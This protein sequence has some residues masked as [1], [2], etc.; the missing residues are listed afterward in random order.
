MKPLFRFS[1]FAGFLLIGIVAYV[2]AAGNARPNVLFICIDDLKPVL[3][4]YGDRL[5]RTPNIDRLAARG[6]VFENAYCNQSLCAPSLNALMSGMRPTS[7]GIYD[8]ATNFRAAV[9]DAVTVAQ[10]FQKHGYRT[11]AVGKI[12]HP[13]HGNRED[14]ASWTVPHFWPDSGSYLTASP[15]K[16]RGPVAPGGADS[17]R[18]VLESAD[19]PDNAYAD[20]ITADEAIRRMRHAKAK[21]DEPQ[22]LAVGFLKPHLPFRVPKKYWDLHDRAKFEPEKITTAPAGAPAYAL[23]DSGELR[24]VAGIPAGPSPAGQQRELIHGYYAAVSYVDAMVGRLLDELDRL[25]LDRNTIVVLWGDHGWHL[26]DHAQWGKKTNYEQATRIPIIVSAPGAARGEKSRALV[27]TVDLYPTLAE[28][29]G[30]PAP[31][32][33]QKL[34]GSSFAATVRNPRAPTKEAIFHAYPR[35]RPPDGQIIGRSV[36]TERYRLVEWKSPGAAASTAELELY[37]Y[38]TDPLE[39]KNLASEAPQVVARLRGL[40]DAQPEALPQVK[41]GA[42]R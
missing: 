28:L 27:E 5:A 24:S 4:S 21:P 39:T 32:V 19:V 33:A 40:L 15:N 42:D 11:E 35:N 10:Y 3:G 23:T 12:M 6:V 25:G 34:D 38:A 18:P 36:R 20:G 37:D 13:A 41:A 7:M 16:K 31:K 30:L 2:R 29:A 1:A 22:F 9:P 14:A 8:L 17:R 26:G